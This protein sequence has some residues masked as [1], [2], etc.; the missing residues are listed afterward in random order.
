[1]EIIAVSREL[2]S[3]LLFVLGDA[4]H[5][6]IYFPCEIAFLKHLLPE[7]LSGTSNDG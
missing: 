2:F 5:Q 3:T 7:S 1:M 6:M 4:V